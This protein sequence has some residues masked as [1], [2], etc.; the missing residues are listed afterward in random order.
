[1]S[2]DKNDGPLKY[3]SGTSGKRLFLRIKKEGGFNM[4][5][6]NGTIYNAVE[7]EPK[8]GDILVVNGKIKKIG[9]NPALSIQFPIQER[10]TASTDSMRI[11]QGCFYF[12]IP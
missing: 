2:A 3:L 11:R 8:V 12:T 7:R 6:K 4:L 9:N 10:K 5:L 1:M